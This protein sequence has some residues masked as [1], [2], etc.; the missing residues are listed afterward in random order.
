MG[1]TKKSRGLIRQMGLLNE[2][3]KRVPVEM[4]SIPVPYRDLPTAL[5]IFR[6]LPR[7]KKVNEG[8][9][10]LNDAPETLKWATVGILS[11]RI[12]HEVNN[13]LMDILGNLSFLE[14]RSMGL[15]LHLERKGVLDGDLEALLGEMREQTRKI[16]SAAER[17][18][19][20][21]NG[22]RIYISPERFKS[23]GG[24]LPEDDRQRRV[25]VVDDE[26]ENL[27]VLRRTLS[28]QNE[29]LPAVSGHQAMAILEKE[30]GKV[31]VIVTDIN[32]SGMNGITFYR[33]VAE[34]FPGLEKRIVFVTGGIFDNEA[35]RFLD[36]VPNLCLEKPFRFEDL[37]R[38]VS[39]A[40][41]VPRNN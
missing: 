10:V 21:V 33:S 3:G 1:T 17:I 14:E 39:E 15:K 41:S 16:A 35:K 27:D 5:M 8:T 12:V 19:E 31:E 37:H 24:P 13:P 20:V 18:R 26:P 7:K 22:L 30:D 23:V 9:R 34:R 38:A 11:S 2:D 29:I 36:M 6:A 40:G 28:E 4:E 32:M 25:L